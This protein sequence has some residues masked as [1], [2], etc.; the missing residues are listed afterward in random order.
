MQTTSFHSD[1]LL[2]TSSHNGTAEAEMNPNRV[3]A[4][5]LLRTVIPVIVLMGTVGNTLSFCVLVR[6]RM[7]S[8]PMYFY[9]TLLAVADTF[10]LYVSAF[11]VWIRAVTQF[12][13]LHM[14]NVGCKMLMFILL[15]SFYM[16][17]WLVVLV[18]LD[19]F[20]V[21]WFP[22]RGY[23]LMRI[24]QAR[25]TAAVLAVV[26]AVY[27]VHVFWTMGLHHLGSS[28]MCYADEDNFFMTH[29]FEY[30]K[31]ISYCVVPFVVVISLNVGILVRINRVYTNA[32]MRRDCELRDMA[33]VYRHQT[34]LVVLAPSSTPSPGH[35]DDAAG[36]VVF[37]PH[38]RQQVAPALGS[39]TAS[40]APHRQSPLNV[41][42][43]RQRRLTRMLLIISFAWLALTAPFTLHS[44]LPEPSPSSSSA[45]FSSQESTASMTASSAFGQLT[46]FG[47]EANNSS[48]DSFLYHDDHDVSQST[49]TSVFNLAQIGR[50]T[51]KS[52]LA[53]E[54]HVST[55][56]T[57]ES[58]ST[59]SASIDPS[60]Y[61]LVKTV[62]FLLVYVNHAINFYLYCLTGKRFRKELA[63]MLSCDRIRLLCARCEDDTADEVAAAAADLAGDVEMRNGRRDVHVHRLPLNQALPSST[64]SR[65]RSGR[66]M[67]KNINP[68]RNSSSELNDQRY[69]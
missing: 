49:V 20:L 2:S 25:L 52:F 66:I 18:T 9:L 5:T 15:C 63:A 43:L 59:P 45:T 8:T 19:R 22:F 40:P 67:M 33:A 14:S 29:V 54:R 26:V 57:S 4:M 12:E 28:P 58:A 31:L 37:M 7:R 38:Q 50:T 36:A 17:A 6:R 47:D 27:N 51:T 32:A 56:S 65:T 61:L 35:L 10:V 60:R 11:K 68:L 24:R 55:S 64:S 23:L 30:L 1:V 13:V 21:V 53:E 41:Q 48:F 39:S 69:S 16:S 3:L 46:D 42:K 62:C 34:P 44:F